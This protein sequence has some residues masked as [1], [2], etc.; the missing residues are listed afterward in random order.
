MSDI[1]FTV[2]SNLTNDSDPALLEKITKS[3][4]IQLPTHIL[5]SR[6]PRNLLA[7]VFS[8]WLPLSTA[9]LISVIE[10][11]PNPPDSQAA[12]LQDIIED[13]PGGD[14]VSP[15]VRDAMINFRSSKDVPAVAYVS[16]M[17]SIPES[18]LPS[19]TRRTGTTL[20]AEEAREMARKKREELARVQSQENETPED[21]F[22]RATSGLATMGIGDEESN[23]RE[24]EGT[25]DPEHLIGFARLY[26]GTLSV[27]DSIYVLPPKFSPRDPHAAPEPKLV[28]ITA[29]YLLMGRS[30]EH[31]ESASAGVVFGIAGLEGHITKT[32]TICSQLEGGINLA[33]ISM[34][35]PPI[36]RVALEPA[37]PGDL[38]KMITGLKLLARSDPCAQYEVLPSGE[39]VIVTAG[40]LHLERC[41]K[42]LR[43]RYARCEIQSGEAIVPYRE[44]IISVPDMTPPKN[45]ELPRGTVQEASA[46]KQLTMQLRVVPLPA[47]ATDFLTKNEGTINRLN[48]S[49]RG[50]HPEVDEQDKYGDADAAEATNEGAGDTSSR[51]LLSIEDFKKQ[52][53]DIFNGAKEE[54]EVWKDVLERTVE[55]GPRKTGPNILVDATPAGDYEKL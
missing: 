15:E 13:S 37:N 10:G 44:T 50:K 9:V 19:K 47:A 34:S 12:R 23:G 35:S 14:F 8:S 16:K 25:E 54:K 5:R 41:L 38:Q 31:L 22:S 27:G 21:S 30:L 42:D 36:V 52:L 11:I 55:F 40:E 18:E 28:T 49:K 6:D 32:G 43:E 46:S 1:L 26:S 17:A 51:N 53:T 3:L 33:G 45:P 7:A 4:S 24:E 39:H 48:R 20:T 29:L 2:A